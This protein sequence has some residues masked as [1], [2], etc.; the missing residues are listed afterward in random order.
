MAG[1]ANRRSGQR[2]V[3]A[4]ARR[5]R[6][7]RAP[8]VAAAARA[9][10]RPATA[11][12]DRGPAGRRAGD[13]VRCARRGAAG[14]PAGASST[15]SPPAGAALSPAA[16]GRDP[17]AVVELPAGRRRARSPGAGRP[18]RRADRSCGRRPWGSPPS[19]STGSMTNV[20]R[21]TG[22]QSLWQARAGRARASTS[23]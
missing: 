16:S 13:G 11:A 20:T 1:N 2:L 22:A 7:R 8:P 17:T 4:A 6:A 10:A 21:L 18:R 23:P 12:G 15:P 14:R 5:A 9:G 19:S 3:S